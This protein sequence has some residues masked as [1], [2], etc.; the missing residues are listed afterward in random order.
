MTRRTLW[1]NWRPATA[2]PVAIEGEAATFVRL[3]ARFRR[4]LHWVTVSRDAVVIGLAGVV[5]VEA[6]LIIRPAASASPLAIG[7]A[8]MAALGLVLVSAYL[9]TPTLRS[10]AAALDLRT[11]RDEGLATALQFAETRDAVACLVHR[12]ASARVAA[13]AP[14]VVFPLEAPPHLRS[15]LAALALVT[16][17]C[18]LNLTATSA[19]WPTARGGVVVSG[20]PAP[21]QTAARQ[22]DPRAPERPVGSTT[23]NG[24]MSAPA[25]PPSQVAP[26]QPGSADPAPSQ[27]PAD[28]VPAESGRA[29]DATASNTAAPPAAAMSS[30]GA[31]GAGATASPQRDVMT[32][33]REPGGTGGRG[34]IGGGAGGSA[35][36]AAEAPVT[37]AGGVSNGALTGRSPGPQ[38]TARPTSKAYA[39]RYR[40]ARARAEVAVQQERIPPRL[41]VHVRDYFA[42]IHPAGLP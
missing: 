17:L 22:Q 5:A 30:G 28:A 32:M 1:P 21:M 2:A 26:P 9:R 39:A 16:V 15:M 33:R 11:R 7:A 14:R 34:G 3:L 35:G 19:R 25:A 4:R 8:A 18:A 13:L 27:S 24:S 42:T 20:G 12:A 38:L 23:P 41:R 31:S 29:T 37:S 40:A 10:T 6:M 36:D